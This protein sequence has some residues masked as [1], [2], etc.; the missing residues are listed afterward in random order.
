MNGEIVDVAAALCNMAL[1]Y[2]RKGE[3]AKAWE[4]CARKHPTCFVRC[5]HMSVCPC[6][7]N[8][9]HIVLLKVSTGLCAYVSLENFVQKM[10][11]F[12]C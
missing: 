11:S 12:F 1:V 7:S 10:E 2:E 9:L 3:Y 5:A 4:L 6:D 8:F